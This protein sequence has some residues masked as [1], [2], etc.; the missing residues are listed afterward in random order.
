MGLRTA[1]A[2]K[3]DL[4][5]SKREERDFYKNALMIVQTFDEKYITGEQSRIQSEIEQLMLK[6]S[7]ED[8]MKNNERLDAEIKRLKSKLKMFNYLILS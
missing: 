3:E 4:N 1:H 5:L 7:P 8:I 6:K 2:I